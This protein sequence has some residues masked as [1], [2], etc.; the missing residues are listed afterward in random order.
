[1]DCDTAR[2]L[3]LFYR[4]GR[5]ADLAAEDVAALEGHLASCPACSAALR[6]RQAADMAIGRAVRAVPVPGGLRA[7]LV[8]RATADLARAWRRTWLTRTAAAAAVVVAG[9]VAW[10][11]YGIL[12]RTP[13]DT[14]AAVAVFDDPGG[15]TRRWMVANGLPEQ[16]EDFDLRLATFRGW[17]ELD[18]RRVPAVVLQHPVAPHQA[19]LYFLPPGRFDLRDAGNAAGSNATARLYKDLPGGWAVL[20]VYTGHD[21]KPFIRVPT[22]PS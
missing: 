6:H 2:T 19:T 10:G 20:V 14:D 1:M 12:T 4:P 9:L 7:A 21:L 18:G 17:G 5:P 13:L 16:P 8:E 11:G 3:L 22:G 15:E